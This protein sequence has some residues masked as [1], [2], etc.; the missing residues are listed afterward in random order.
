MDKQTQEIIKFTQ[1]L[2][3]IPSQSYIDSE[4]GVANLVFLLMT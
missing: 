2:V 3:A 1:E 4:S